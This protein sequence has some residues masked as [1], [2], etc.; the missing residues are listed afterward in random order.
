MHRLPLSKLDVYPES[1]DSKSY[2]CKQKPLYP[3][4]KQLHSGTIKFE[5]PTLYDSVLDLPVVN[6]AVRPRE[7][8]SEGCS[9]NKGA[10]NAVVNK[11]KQSAI[12]IRFFVIYSSVP[13]FIL[14]VILN[15]LQIITYENQC[16]YDY[17]KINNKMV[18]DIRLREKCKTLALTI[19]RT[20]N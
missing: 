8:N 18:R 12:K 14:I 5:A 1:I 13:H 16:K 20:Y 19:I 2:N 15:E 3:V 9:C 17:E 4:S 7:T 10:K 11:L 6:H